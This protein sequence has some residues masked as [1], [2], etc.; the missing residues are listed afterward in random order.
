MIWYENG[1][2]LDFSTL[3]HTFKI[4]WLKHF[5]RNPTSIW[6]TIPLQLLT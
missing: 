6:H 3:N 5:Y 1:N 2:F 4:N